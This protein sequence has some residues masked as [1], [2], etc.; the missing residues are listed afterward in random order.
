MWPEL[1]DLAASGIARSFLAFC[2]NSEIHSIRFIRE[3]LL[4]PNVIDL[5]KEYIDMP[6]STK[7][8]SLS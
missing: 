5:S 3:K 1:A 2:D 6:I 8:D 7:I 4:K